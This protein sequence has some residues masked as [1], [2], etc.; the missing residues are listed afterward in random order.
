MINFFLIWSKYKIL[1]IFIYFFKDERNHLIQ[2]NGINGP[3]LVGACGGGIPVAQVAMVPVLPVGAVNSN[4][5][6]TPNS[7]PN[8]GNGSGDCKYDEKKVI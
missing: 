8:L 7:I 1:I 5:Q 4:E 2:M 3:L 6:S